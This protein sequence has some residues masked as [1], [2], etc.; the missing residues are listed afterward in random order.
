MTENEIIESVLNRLAKLEDR[1]RIGEDIEQIKQ[2]FQ[3]YINARTLRDTKAELSY[4]AEDGVLKIGENGIRGKAAL[5]EYIAAN[6]AVEGIKAKPV[7]TEGQ[8]LVHPLINVNGDKANGR[9]LQ[10]TLFCH[11]ITRQALFWTQAEYDV[12][13]VRENGEW[14][15]SY[16][17]W[18]PLIMPP[19]PPPYDYPAPLPSNEK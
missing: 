15:I 13:Y 7:P 10:Y 5:A 4:F 1:V 6:D 8:F 17:R 12:D 2:L 14:K 9:W 11:R 16:I 18:Q 3:Q 19:G